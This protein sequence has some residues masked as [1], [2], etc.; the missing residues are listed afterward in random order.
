MLQLKHVQR[1]LVSVLIAVGALGA[2]LP[3]QTFTTAP[4]RVTLTVNGGATEKVTITVS[5][6]DAAPIM[7]VPRS[8]G[9]RQDNEGR[10]VLGN[11]FDSAENWVTAEASE[12]KIPAGGSRKITFSIT[13]PVG[14]AP[15]SHYV[16][17]AIAAQSSGTNQV[18]LLGELVSLLTVQVAGIVDE[19][20]AIT[21][22]N[23]PTLITKIE[24]FPISITLRN[25]G[26]IEVPLTGQMSITTLGKREVMSQNLPL[27]NILLPDST[28]HLKPRVQLSKFPYPGP[29]LVTINTTYGRTGQVA[30]AS[31]VV[32]YLPRWSLVIFCGAVFILFAHW[33]RK[34]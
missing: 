29:Y 12:I 6:P 31:Q 4:A 21:E 3:A 11:V 23:I 10:T 26:T 30:V 18:A 25:T 13:P 19:H 5:N 16:G 8:I 14:T 2:C 22:W 15:G 1:H 32:W 33:F 17:L 20:V 24:S 34:R 28:R 9:V 27:G 7:V